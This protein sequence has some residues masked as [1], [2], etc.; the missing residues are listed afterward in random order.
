MEIIF[1]AARFILSES[2]H[3]LGWTFAELAAIAAVMV[4]RYAQRA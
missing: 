2:I 1:V 4:S 3:V